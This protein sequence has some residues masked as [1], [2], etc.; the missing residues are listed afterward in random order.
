MQNSSDYHIHVIIKPDYVFALR[1]VPSILCLFECGEVQHFSRTNVLI[2][3]I[4]YRI[5]PDE[6]YILS[7]PTAKN[8][9]VRGFERT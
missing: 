9:E 4:M 2:Y 6:L 1:R 8:V 5:K 7:F 3:L